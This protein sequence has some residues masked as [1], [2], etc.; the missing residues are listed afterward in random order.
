MTFRCKTNGFRAPG[1]CVCSVY[2]VSPVR[3][4]ARL[5]QGGDTEPSQS[6]RESR[7]LRG[8]RPPYPGRALW[9]LLDLLTAQPYTPHTSRGEEKKGERRREERGE[10]PKPTE[11]RA[12]S[13]NSCPA[14]GKHTA[15]RKTN[16][17]LPCVPCDCEHTH[18]QVHTH[19]FM[20]THTLC[21]MGWNIIAM[22]VRGDT[23]VIVRK[24]AW[25]A[26]PHRIQWCASYRRA[27][28]PVCS[29]PMCSKAV[30]STAV[31]VPVCSTAV[32]T[33]AVCDAAVRDRKSTRL[34]SSHL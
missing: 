22:E 17:L 32:Y 12:K 11:S 25:H 23:S 2:A 28:S 15:L 14:L 16:P 19:T 26:G 18:T 29:T 34:N 21:A 4:P 24:K 20:D 1:A 13:H 33:T 9:R 30:S 8:F 3:D 31:C 7:G 6:P 5:K 27:P 10:E